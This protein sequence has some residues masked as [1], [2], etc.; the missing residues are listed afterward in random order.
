MKSIL[1]VSLYEFKQFLQIVGWIALPVTVIAILLTI[2]FHYRSKK[3]VAMELAFPD[4][5]DRRLVRRS[6]ALGA[7][8]GRKGQGEEGGIV[9][10]LVEVLQQQQERLRKQEAAIA[11]LEKQLKH[12]DEPVLPVMGAEQPAAVAS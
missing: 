6:V 5:R 11:R 4:E 9:Q 3:G 1:L 12:R 7:L 8:G 2:Y 10:E